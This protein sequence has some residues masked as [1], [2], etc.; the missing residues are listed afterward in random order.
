MDRDAVIAAIYAAAMG[1]DNWQSALTRLAEC[2][3]SACVSID[4]YDIVGHQGSVLASNVPPHRAVVKYQ[5]EFRHVNAL[6]EASLPMLCAG[7]VCYY[8]QTHDKPLVSAPRSHTDS[9]S[10]PTQSSLLRLFL[11]VSP[12]KTTQFTAIK[13]RG[14]EGF[15]DRELAVFAELKTHL[16][17]AWNGSRHLLATQVQLR[18]PAE[19]W[20][21]IAHAVLVIDQQLKILFFNCAAEKLLREAS[22]VCSAGGSLRLLGAAVNET[23]GSALK[24]LGSGRQQIVSLMDRGPLI[25]LYQLS[26]GRTALFVSESSQPRNCVPALQAAFHLTRHE[27][28]LIDALVRGIDLRRYAEQKGIGY[29]TARSHLKRAMHKNAWHRQ[30]EIVSRVLH[31]LL[32]TT[33]LDSASHPDSP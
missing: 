25:T 17:Q 30:S 29:E 18:T 16:V 14:V 28:E 8:S 10:A 11:S 7:A 33:L 9:D 1:L 4:S 12:Q 31:R 6:I 32:P 13:A 22:W 20:D 24:N 26:L 27:A 23:L 5:R 21:Q 15:S 2:T 3:D 19:L